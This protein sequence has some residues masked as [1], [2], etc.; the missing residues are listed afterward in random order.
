MPNWKTNSKVYRKYLERI[1]EMYKSRQD[2]KA[3]LE[4]I[5]TA[6]A[7]IVFVLFAIRPTF[8]TIAKLYKEKGEKENIIK[9]L[10][11]KRKNLQTAE[12]N[13]NNYQ[14]QIE[15]LEETL[16]TEA[17]PNEIITQIEALSTQA[18]V[19]ILSHKTNQV[20]LTKSAEVPEQGITKEFSIDLM[21]T[22]SYEQV[23]QFVQSLE[24]FRR[25]F[26]F[27]L[28]SLQISDDDSDEIFGDIIANLSIRA[29]YYE[30]KE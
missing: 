1:V 9:T 22:G 30:Q 3:Y 2:L 18:N 28:V 24:N 14:S 13:F 7:A 10:E 20:Q 15:L 11:Q 21:A 5:L 8:L 16:P 25:P 12:N 19:L 4:L 17:K 6:I 29:Y 27:G 26:S 23:Y